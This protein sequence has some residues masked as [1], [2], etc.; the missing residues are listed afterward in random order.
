MRLVKDHAEVGISEARANGAA[1]RV[2]VADD[3]PFYREGLAR[4]LRQSGIKVVAE[5]PRVSS[6]PTSS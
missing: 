3:H 6:R 2:V 5:A 4:L 1:L